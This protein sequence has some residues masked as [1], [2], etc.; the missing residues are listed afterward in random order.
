MLARLHKFKLPVRKRMGTATCHRYAHAHN[1]QCLPAAV[2]SETQGYPPGQVPSG[3]SQRSA[4]K[5]P[6]NISTSA[7]KKGRKSRG[8]SA[9]PSPF[10]QDLDDPVKDP[11]SP[12]VQWAAPLV[13]SS[14]AGTPA[15]AIKLDDLIPME[16]T[17][18]GPSV[19]PRSGA[20]PAGA[21]D[22]GDGEDDILPDMAD[23]D[24][25]A[26]LSWQSQSTANLK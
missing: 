22:D 14:R 25:S 6:A 18:P 21:D 3:S 10:H 13:S 11:G 4:G 19:V 20:V 16:S 24:Y 8:A 26:Q 1:A 5:Q 17:Q 15:G 7:M 9:V 23:D 12:S 2:M